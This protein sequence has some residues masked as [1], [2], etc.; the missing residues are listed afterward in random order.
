MSTQD[1]GHV[2]GGFNFYGPQY[3]RFGSGLAAELRREVYGED[4]GQQGWRTAAEQAEIARDGTSLRKVVSSTSPAARAAPRW[5]W[6]SAP[7]A[8]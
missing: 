5:R 1:E 6:S 8:I 4:L 3:A 7:D 2:S